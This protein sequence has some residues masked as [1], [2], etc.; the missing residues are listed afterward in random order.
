MFMISSVKIFF[1]NF[2][3][4]TVIDSTIHSSAGQ[5]KQLG[6]NTM[7]LMSLRFTFLASACAHVLAGV[8]FSLACFSVQSDAVTQLGSICKPNTW[9]GPSTTKHSECS[10]CFSF[11]FLH[12]LHVQLF[13]RYST[14]NKSV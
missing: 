14:S 2:Y 5:E 6:T 7:L 13:I 11:L 10:L 8:W 3:K 4:F 1:C 9:S 12:V